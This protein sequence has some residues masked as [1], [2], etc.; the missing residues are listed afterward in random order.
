MPA[1]TVRVSEKLSVPK[2]TPAAMPSGKWWMAMAATNSAAERDASE[3]SLAPIIP[4]SRGPS[5]LSALR[6]AAPPI[7]PSGVRKIAALPP[8]SND[9]ATSPS[10]AAPSIIPAA[11]P[12]SESS[13]LGGM[14]PSRKPASAPAR[15]HAAMAAAVKN[16][17]ISK[18]FNPRSRARPRKTAALYAIL[19]RA[20]GGG[21]RE[22]TPQSRVTLRRCC[23][24]HCFSSMSGRK[25]LYCVSYAQL[26]SAQSANFAT[27]RVEMPMG[28]SVPAPATQPPGQAIPSS[29]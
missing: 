12:V 20:A 21:V 11:A 28:W 3:S 26:Y 6:K 1:V 10:A 2:L 24:Y 7:T 9:G 14:F 19:C 5:R 18:K 15:Q 17:Y 16:T 13:S 29:R 4:V 27:A 25:S 22:K 23:L 8:S